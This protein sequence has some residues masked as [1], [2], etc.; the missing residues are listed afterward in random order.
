MFPQ[1]PSIGLS[2][3]PLAWQL[4]YVT[5]II[6]SDPDLKPFVVSI[7]GIVQTVFL[8]PLENVNIP[9]G[10]SVTG[11]SLPELLERLIV[12]PTPNPQLVKLAFIKLLGDAGVVEPHTK[13]IPSMVPLRR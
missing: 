2:A 13:V 12:G 9:D 3:N 1:F 5:Y 4:Q 6:A 7:D 8:L 10:N 11:A